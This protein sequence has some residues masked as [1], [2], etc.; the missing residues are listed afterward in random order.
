MLLVVV[1]LVWLFT[2][3]EAGAAF[4]DGIC[5]QDELDKFQCNPFISGSTLLGALEIIP[6]A[7]GRWPIPSICTDPITSQAVPCS[8][9]T[10]RFSG[11]SGD[12]QIN[13]LIS[14][15][16]QLVNISGTNSAGCSQFITDGSGDSTTGFGKNILTFNV[17]RV[18]FNPN[19]TPDVPPL[20]NIVIAAR[21]AVAD[22]TVDQL[23]AGK[24]VAASEILG[25]SGPVPPIST[26]TQT[27][28]AGDG[29]AVTVQEDQ[30]GN[31]ISGIAPNG[32]ILHIEDLILCIPKPGVTNPGFPADYTCEP[33]TF[34]SSN[35]VV[36]TTGSDPCYVNRLGQAF[37]W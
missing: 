2:C 27:F 21:P 9:F 37:C 3:K 7:Q 28:T 19:P 10:Y 23:K 8:L 29:S 22:R 14:D 4:G 32:R 20:A 6:S 15:R 17:C 33:L 30:Q 36:K 12:N 24:L 16:V 31:I 5:Q 26:T 13:L 11:P 1:A 35:A 25:P 18:A 34:T